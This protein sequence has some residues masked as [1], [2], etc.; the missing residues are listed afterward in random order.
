[1]NFYVG[2]D[3][4]KLSFLSS[5]LTLLVLS[6]CG[7]RSSDSGYETYSGSVIKGPLENA[8]VFLGY[9]GDGVLGADEPSVRTGA[10][11]SF[12]LEA[13]S[14]GLVLWLGRNDQRQCA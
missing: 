13:M 11:G 9:N 8:L 6:A 14:R 3:R 5:P 4:K 2:N 7:G 1:M 10:D 12:S